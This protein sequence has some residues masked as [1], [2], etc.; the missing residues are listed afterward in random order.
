MLLLLL[1]KFMLSKICMETVVVSDQN[2]LGCGCVDTNWTL[3]WSTDATVIFCIIINESA[4]NQ[5]NVIMVI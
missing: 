2:L 3:I 5:C 4:N 1:M